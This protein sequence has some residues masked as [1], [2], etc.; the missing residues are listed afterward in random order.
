MKPTNIC[1]SK[2]PVP[3]KNHIHTSQV[4]VKMYQSPYQLYYDTEIS[5]VEKAKVTIIKLVLP[6]SFI[7][8]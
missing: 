1:P 5:D 3:L 7:L 8:L 4:K 6:A 2:Y